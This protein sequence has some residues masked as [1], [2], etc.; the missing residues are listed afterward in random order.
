VRLEALEADVRGRSAR[1][2]EPIYPAEPVRPAPD[3]RL[4]SI[5]GDELTMRDLMRGALPV[6]M[7]F[8]DPGCGP[9]RALAPEVARW[10]ADDASSL[11][12][13]V[14]AGGQPAKV[15][16]MARR[17]QLRDVVLVDRDAP[18]SFGVAGTPA[19][20]LIDAGGLV[21]GSPG[22]GADA[23]RS[24]RQRGL[25]L[26]TR[27]GPEPTGQHRPPVR[28]VVG[29]SLTGVV[30]EGI[31]GRWHDLG[32][33]DGEADTSLL[34]F[35]NPRCGFCQR[36]LPDLREVEA[37]RRRAERVVLVASGGAEANREPGL[38]L[39]L[40]LDD[41]GTVAASMG[42]RGTPSACRI[43]ATGRIASQLAVG[44]PAVRELLL[45]P[46]PDEVVAADGQRPRAR[47]GPLP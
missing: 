33:P 20:V 44:E 16:Q 11:S 10:Q 23:V 25:A 3:V 40:L 45:E 2:V 32:A 47:D 30:L 38:R 7:V 17:H 31:D 35:W 37:E 5:D 41:N 12:V 27:L 4:R 36:L 24:L 19:A 22:G 28:R 42:V 43:D 39:T 26:R 34:V 6:L 18:H 15:E 8:L 14:A 21:H 29:D 46:G 9:C 1:L 13:V